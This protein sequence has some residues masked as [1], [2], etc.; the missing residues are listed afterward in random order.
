MLI[1]CHVHLDTYS[2]REVSDIL[3]RGTS[4]GVHHVVSAG[5]TLASSERSIELSRLFAELLSAVGI[6]PMDIRGPVDQSTY[7]E[8]LGLARSSDK[9]VAISEIGLDYIEGAPERAMQFQAFREQIRVAR[10]LSLP[11]VF[12]S[13]EAHDEVF[14]VLREERGY[15]V[16]GVMHYFQGDHETAAKAIDLGFHISLARPLLRLPELQQV[17]AKLPLQR[18]VLETDAAPQPFKAR[19]ENWTEPRHVRDVAR[20]VA[21]LQNRSVEEVEAATTA[22]VRGLLGDRWPTVEMYVGDER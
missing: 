9:V 1:D 3:D 4:A 13:R 10:E 20:K 8:L 5:T 22:N 6:H 15:E 21:E 16:G 19:R 2:D 7:E 11:L 17:A 18:I 14:R 12:H